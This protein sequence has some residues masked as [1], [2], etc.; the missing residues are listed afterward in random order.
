MK[1]ST[2]SLIELL[3]FAVQSCNKSPGWE[4]LHVRGSQ[5]RKALAK[6]ITL[7]RSTV[8]RKALVLLIK[9]TM[10]GQQDFREIS[11]RE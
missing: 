1:E 11:N 8:G 2:R 3:R 7:R 9:N 4:K 10:D 6:N 5:D